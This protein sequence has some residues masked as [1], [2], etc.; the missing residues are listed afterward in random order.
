M[1]KSSFLISILL[2]STLTL[3]VLAQQKIKT[4][5]ACNYA[6]GQIGE[7]TLT[8]IDP[9]E[10]VKEIAFQIMN[11]MAIP[12]DRFIVM[13]AGDTRQVP[14]AQACKAINGQPYIIVNTE[15]ILKVKEKSTKWAVYAVMAH[16][17]GHY[18]LAHDFGMKGARAKEQEL[19]ADKYAGSMLA[20]FG[21]KYEE[22][23]QIIDNLELPGES[24][25]HPEK[26]A[27]KQSMLIGFEDEKKRIRETQ[28]TKFY[29]D[30]SAFKNPNL[31]IDTSYV[32]M[33]QDDDKVEVTVSLPATL[34]GKRLNICLKHNGEALDKTVGTGS[35][36]L[37][38]PTKKIIW[39]YRESSIQIQ[40]TDTKMYLQVY[41]FD[42]DQHIPILSFKDRLALGSVG[43]VGFGCLGYGISSRIQGKN[44]YKIYSEVR[45]EDASQYATESRND[46]YN[47]ANKKYVAG[48]VFIYGGACVLAGSTFWLLKRLMAGPRIDPKTICTNYPKVTW[49]PLAVADNSQT[50]VGICLRF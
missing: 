28:K 16:E 39:N 32:K 38:S 9:T 50:R 14:N 29:F 34:N 40:G 8:V 1:R 7:Q 19:A 47:R 21:A 2:L 10:Q 45:T 46:R 18:V 4:T 31:I 43:A 17:V 15:F 26:G 27:R 44:I 48:Q 20:R 3:P 41:V 13:A 36:I 6:S 24:S 12:K 23:A 30:K 22:V 33:T 37:Y 11:E 49:E 42:M 5:G 25:T 35:G